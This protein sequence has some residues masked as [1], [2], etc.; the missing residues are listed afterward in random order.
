MGAPYGTYPGGIPDLPAS[1]TAEPEA[2]LVYQCPV[3]GYCEGILGRSAET[4]RR[5]FDGDGEPIIS[6]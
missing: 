1:S 6:T 2:G 3:T 4:D 5:L